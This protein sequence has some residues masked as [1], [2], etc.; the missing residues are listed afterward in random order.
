MRLLLTNPKS[1]FG[2]IVFGGIVLCALLAPVIAQHPPDEIVALPGLSPSRDYWFGTTDQGYDVFAQVIWGARISLA[3]GFAA[4]VISTTIAATLGMVAAYFGGWV[5]DVLNT[6]TNVFIVIP[7]LPLLIVVYSFIPSRG[8]VPMVLILGLTTWAVEARILRSQALSLRNRDF[9][10]AAKV[11]GESDVADRLRRDHAEHGEPDRRRL[12]ARL[13]PLDHLRRG[14]RVPR[15]RRREQDHLGDDAL[16]GAEQLERAPGR[17][18]ALRLPGRRARALRRGARV[19]QLRRRRAREPAAAA[20][21]EGSAVT[22]LVQDAAPAIAPA[23]ETEVLLELDDLVVDYLEAG[24]PLRAVDHV[25]LTIRAGEIV[26]LAGE[27]G[28]GK[29]TTANAILSILQPP[30]EVTGG[31]DPVPRGRRRRPER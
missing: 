28:C 16:L 3:V 4:A 11:S 7:A 25:N 22:G 5:D 14:A 29:T 19:H 27:S 31:R 10:L 12:P 21:A 30:A 20:A 1:C 9:V 2:I 17:V 18:V 24:R 13:L 23:V 6:V 26:G 8:P 15:V